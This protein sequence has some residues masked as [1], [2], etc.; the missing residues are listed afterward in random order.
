MSETET[1]N[2][3]K[4]VYKQL[5]NEGWSLWWWIGVPVLCIFFLVTGVQTIGSDWSAKLGQGVRGTFT[6]RDADP[7]K[8]NCSWWGTFTSDDG[9][10]R[11]DDVVFAGYLTGRGDTT[12]ALDVGDPRVV[13]PVDGGSAWLENIAWMVA[14]TVFLIAW[15]LSIRR[16]RRAR[17]D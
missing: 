7:C 9:H 8:A 6:A 5:A 3:W 12:A 13:Y 2:G 17:N 10:T 14:A 11:R 16:H 1:K 4:K 15:A